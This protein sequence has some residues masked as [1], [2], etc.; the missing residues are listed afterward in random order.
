MSEYAIKTVYLDMDGVLANF[1]KRW[2]ELYNHSPKETRAVKR[3]DERW[4]DFIDKYQF[5]SL[6]LFPGAIELVEYLRSKPGL[7]IEI[8]SSSG[9]EKTHDKVVPQKVEWLKKQG[10][11]FK[12]NIVPGKHKKRLY[13]NPN[14]LLIDDTESVILDFVDANGYAI[15]H[16][17]ANL[18][19][20]SLKSYGI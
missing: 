11:D 16:T 2:L 12:P 13:A 9:G 18:T 15:M 8:L 5:A 14:C 4:Y 10:F 1:E 19:I 7:N 17:D 3:F 6:D 20:Q